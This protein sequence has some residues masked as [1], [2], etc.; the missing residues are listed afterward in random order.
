ME[1]WWIRLDPTQGSEASKTRPCLILQ[2]N[3]GNQKSDVTII[4][5]FL[6][7]RNYPFVV[8]VKPSNLNGLDRQ[9]GLNLSQMRVVYYAR[10]QSKL[11]KLEDSYS[12]KIEEAI[13]IELGIFGR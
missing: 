8:N 1:I 9:R 5:P 12:Q 7:A 3:I 6:E 2:N 4:A 13:A 11:G 10:L